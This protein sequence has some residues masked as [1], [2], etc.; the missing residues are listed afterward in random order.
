MNMA[1]Q[2]GAAGRILQQ[3]LSHVL[4]QHLLRPA[5]MVNP[6]WAPVLPE[7]LAARFAE[8]LSAALLLTLDHI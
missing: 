7:P 3:E 6:G 8:T 5:L 4:L 1:L 2:V